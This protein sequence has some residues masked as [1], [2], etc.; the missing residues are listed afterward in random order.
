MELLCLKQNKQYLRIVEEGYELTDMNKASVY[1]ISQTEKVQ[2]LFR[3][4][5]NETAELK[6][7][8]LT[9]TEEEYHSAN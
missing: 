4:F 2:S 6:I 9:I 8:K 1:P 7:V 5:Q 3:Q